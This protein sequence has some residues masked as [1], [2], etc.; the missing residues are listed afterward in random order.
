MNDSNNTNKGGIGFNG[1]LAITFIVLKLLGVIEWGWL[2]VLSPVW[3]TTAISI[4]IL[5]VLV[6]RNR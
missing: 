5:I 2:W 3:I 4:V 6:I 1:L